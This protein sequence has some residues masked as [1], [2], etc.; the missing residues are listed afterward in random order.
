MT[1]RF[2]R[3]AEKVEYWQVH[4]LDAGSPADTFAAIDALVARVAARLLKSKK[5]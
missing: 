5:R 4:D 3:H 1:A 2:P